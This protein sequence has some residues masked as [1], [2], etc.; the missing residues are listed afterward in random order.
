MAGQTGAGPLVYVGTYTEGE[1]RPRGRAEGIYVYQL[2]PATGALA[3][4]HTTPGVVNPSFLAL[5]PNGRFLYA[6]NE[7]E[8]PEG[9][10]GGEV[11]AFALDPATGAATFLNRQ[12]SHGNA[13]CHLCVDGEGRYVLAANYSSGSVAV[14]PVEADGR[15]APASDVVQHRGGSVHPERQRG[16]HAHSVTLDPSGR[17]ALVADLGLD[18]VLTYRLDRQRGTLLPHDT[19]W[20]QVTAGA[21]PRHLAFHPGGRFA[22]V[23]DELDSTL[24]AFAYDGERGTL[25]ELQRLSTL[26]AGYGGTSHCA[27]VHVAPSGRFVYGSNRG[28]DSIAGFRVDQ[29][30]G[31]L[32]AL[33][34]T[35]TQGRTPRNFNIDPTGTYLFA[36]N[37]NSDSI[38]TF[39]IDAE[40]GALAPAGPVAEVPTPVCIVFAPAV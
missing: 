8:G 17:F 16:P 3:H 22:Y 11:S 35:P 34:H 26:P 27:D 31:R 14:L 23:I 15:L 33:G 6:V 10:P 18:Q 20:A 29:Q 40:T 9:Q 32:S 24:T 2:D 25:R 1:Q 39:R 28:H 38:V 4:R 7:V 13:P 21:G 5:H 36:A 30:S 12:P 37:Q 19:P